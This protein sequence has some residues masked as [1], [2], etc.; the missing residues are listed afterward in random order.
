MQA[1]YI[2]ALDMWIINLAV[3]SLTVRVTAG[4]TN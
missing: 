4:I 3:L 2:K 1:T